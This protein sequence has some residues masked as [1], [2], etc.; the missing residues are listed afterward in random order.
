MST[1]IVAF[2]NGPFEYFETSYISPLS[3]KTRP[4]RAYGEFHLPLSSHSKRQY[5]LATS[6]LIGQTKYALEVGARVLPCYEEVFDIEYPLPKLDF[7][8]V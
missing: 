1:Y 5:F 6:D 2:A 4:L 8:V 7:L 3:G